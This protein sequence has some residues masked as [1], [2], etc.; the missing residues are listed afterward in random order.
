MKKKLLIL[1][2]SENQ[3]P[4]FERAKRLGVYTILCDSR[5]NVPCSKIADKQWLIDSW[6]INNIISRASEE[7]IDGII[8]NSEPR[9][10]DMS[11][12]ASRLGLRC[13]SKE[14]TLLYKNKYLMREFCVSHGFL[15]PKFKNCKTYEEAEAFF[16]QIG[17]KCIRL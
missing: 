4:L 10:I 7:K 5:P 2:G 12:I 14:Q 8:T 15:S 3:L 6:D 1:V 13:L 17:Q 9:F 16:K 11:I